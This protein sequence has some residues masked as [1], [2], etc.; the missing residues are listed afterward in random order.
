MLKTPSLKPRISFLTT[1]N[2]CHTINGFYPAYFAGHLPV[3][4]RRARPNPPTAVARVA[5]AAEQLLD[6]RHHWLPARGK[7]VGGRVGPPFRA[8]C[9]RQKLWHPR[10]RNGRW[11]F[12]FILTLDLVDLTLMLSATSNRLC[13]VPLLHEGLYQGRADGRHC[14]HNCVSQ[15]RLKV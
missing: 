10:I 7:H 5:T 4:V 13:G 2:N 8:V 11:A 6:L 15:I 1:V 14:L 9:G 3:R 12:G